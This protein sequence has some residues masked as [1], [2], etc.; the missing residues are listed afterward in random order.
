VKVI[1]IIV[2]VVVTAIGLG[3]YLGAL[4]DFAARGVALIP[5]RR[6]VREALRR[7]GAARGLNPD[8]P[9][10][11]GWVE[12]Q[13]ILDSVGDQGRSVGPT[14]IQR[15][16][17]AN[18]GYTG[19]GDELRYDPDLAAEW[20]ARLMIA[21]ARN[22]EGVTLQHTP[23]TLEDLAAWW[24]AG[25]QAIEHAPGRT[26]EVYAPKLLAALDLVQETPPEGTA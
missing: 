23:T 2:G 24:N 9:D 26:Q 14:Q 25:Q 7:E 4:P 15:R 12:S 3:G 11:I 10:A 5:S 17:L 16:T 8:W 22:A 21:G 19:T 13:W 20:T 18:N 6:R 1:L